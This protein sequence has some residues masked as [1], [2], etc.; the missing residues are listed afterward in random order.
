MKIIY[1]LQNKNLTKYFI[2]GFALLVGVLILQKFFLLVVL[3]GLSLV[4]SYFIGTYQMSKSVG[5]ELVTFT[6]VLAGFVFGPTTGAFIGLVLIISH[7]IIGHFAA[8]IYVVWVLPLYL[9]AGVLAGTV[10]GFDFVTLGLYTALA[11]NGIGIV[12]T[13]IA[14]MQNLGSY[15]PFAITNVIFNLIVFS[16]FG[17]A[18]ISLLK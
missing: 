8:G 12:L 3:V 10:S 6:T 13:A 5:M 1:V 17:P 7:L 9:A 18:V 15:I 16:Q 14:Y 4:I 2:F 11:I